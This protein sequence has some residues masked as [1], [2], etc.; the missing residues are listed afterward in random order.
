MKKYIVS[1]NFVEHDIDGEKFLLRTDDSGIKYP[2]LY[3]LN[4]TSYSIY[5]FV[6]S[7]SN[8]SFSE[9]WSYILSTYAPEKEMINIKDIQKCVDDYVTAGIFIPINDI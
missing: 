6:R 2:K 8:A 1:S 5:N 9:I 3:I 4:D 7:V